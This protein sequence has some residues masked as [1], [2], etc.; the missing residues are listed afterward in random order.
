MFFKKQNKQKKNNNNKNKKLLQVT[1][2]SLAQVTYSS[3]LWANGSLG[4]QTEGFLSGD[5]GHVGKPFAD[6]FWIRPTSLF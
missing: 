1:V 2:S 3:K 6:V 4:T 5:V